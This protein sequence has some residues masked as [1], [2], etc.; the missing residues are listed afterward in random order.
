MRL[1][2]HM[3]EHRQ[4]RYMRA[5]WGPRAGEG[6]GE[7]RGEGR[8]R[9]RPHGR[10][11]RS[12]RILG[13]GELRFLLL[14]LIGEKPRHGYDL[15]KAIEEKVAG[16]Y[17][18]SAGVIYPTLTLL[19]DMGWI[20][21]ETAED[22]KKL[23]TVT[24][25]GTL[26]LQAN[27][28]LIDDI[29]ARLEQVRVSVGDNAEKPAGDGAGE[30]GAEESEW[31]DPRTFRGFAKIPVMRGFKALRRALRGKLWSGPLSEAQLAAVA[32]ILHDAAKKISEV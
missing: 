12:G 20:R 31:A 15:I 22:S 9:G 16:A 18:P 8:G 7:G 6:A 10:F 1:F 32:A 13:H 2:K 4:R 27:K 3:H 21:V 25:E 28:T 23:Y 14:A 29:F 11:G 26:A 30:S 5:G 17:S 19:E 24:P